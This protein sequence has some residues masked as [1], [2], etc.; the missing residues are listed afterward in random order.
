MV[1]F[2]FDCD[3]G[4]DRISLMECIV[5]TARKQDLKKYI[6]GLLCGGGGGG[7]GGILFAKVRSI[8]FLFFLSFTLE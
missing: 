3:L 2:V 7:V 8:I 6:F 1:Y 5:H 4:V